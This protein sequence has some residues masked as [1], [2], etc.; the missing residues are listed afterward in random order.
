MFAFAVGVGNDPDPVAPVRGANGASRYAVP[1]RIKP[2]RG[3]VPEN[4][5]NPSGEKSS[6]VLDH[7]V[8]RSKLANQSCVLGPKTRAFP[9][10]PCSLTG[11]GEVLAGESAG[12]DV[13]P[14]DGVGSD[15]PDIRHAKHC[16]PVLRKNSLTVRVDFT[17]PHAAHS[18]ALEAKVKIRR[19]P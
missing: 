11:V 9:V 7:H 5:V 19:S 6:N 14:R 2:A 3:Q 15:V 12:E 17:L 10:E 13:D 8:P 18:R 16:R 1:L 4:T